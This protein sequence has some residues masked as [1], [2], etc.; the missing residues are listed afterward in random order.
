[1]GLYVDVAEIGEAPE[2]TP[3][4]LPEEQ[5]LCRRYFQISVSSGRFNAGAAEFF[6]VHM[7]YQPMR[8][9]P[10]V[11]LQ[12]TVA[13]RVNIDAAYPTAGPVAAESVTINILSVGAGDVQEIGRVWHLDADL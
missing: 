5:A 3:A 11:A 12:A 2:W 9:V 10:S 1:V 8:A 13:S 7:Y 6:A 4:I